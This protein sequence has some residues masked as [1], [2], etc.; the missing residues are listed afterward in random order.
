MENEECRMK[1]EPAAGLSAV[2]LAKAEAAGYPRLRS[3]WPQV[4]DLTRQAPC[5]PQNV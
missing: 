5:P 2:A 1:N 3:A 4:E